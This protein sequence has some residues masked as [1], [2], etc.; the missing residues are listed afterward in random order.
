[1][2]RNTL[3]RSEC[4]FINTSNDYAESYNNTYYITK[5]P[6]LY[7]YAYYIK[8]IRSQYE[9]NNNGSY[10]SISAFI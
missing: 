3:H 7:S 8:Y 6:N 5:Y 1:M 2:P 10:C 9:H 4:M